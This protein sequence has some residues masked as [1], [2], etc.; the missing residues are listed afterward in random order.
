MTSRS[1]PNLVLLALFSVWG[2]WVTRNQLCVAFVS[3]SDPTSILRFA[4]TL[5]PLLL[6]VALLLFAGSL[7]GRKQTA[8]LGVALVLQVLAMT[9]TA[10][11]FIDPDEPVHLHYAWNLSQGLLPYRD[12]VSIYHHFWHL[13]MVP[14]MRMMAD[15]LRVVYLAKGITVLTTLAAIGVAGAV[16][17]RLGAHPLHVAL[18]ALSIGA[19]R[20]AATETRPDPFCLLLIL[21][22]VLCLQADSAVRAGLCVGTAYL[23]TQKSLLYGAALGAGYVMS[24]CKAR[25]FARFV[26]T[27]VAVSS[28]SFLIAA[29]LG[30][31]PDYWRG[32]YVYAAMFTRY[33]AKVPFWHSNAVF[34][35]LDEMQSSPLLWA[36]AAIGAAK[37]L[38]GSKELLV[39]T[40]FVVSIFNFLLGRI[41]YH[42][43]T[44]VL[45]L[46]LAILAAVGM[47][48]FTSTSVEKTLGA[49]S[50]SFSLLVLTFVSLSGWSVA[51]ST[52]L[53]QTEATVA[54]AAT[55]P[56]D[57]YHGEDAPGDYSSPI[58]RPQ[59]SY[60]DS[61]GQTMFSV[62]FHE[63]GYVPPE[64]EPLDMAWLPTSPPKVMKFANK[65]RERAALELLAGAGIFYRA[66][67][68]LWVRQDAS[69]GAGHLP[70]ISGW[71][72]LGRS[73]SSRP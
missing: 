22:A 9:D 21:L 49:A 71:S 33:F 39:P 28:L 67:K 57:T 70:S 43:Y 40:M 54:L 53:D 4:A 50:A 13:L 1:T 69:G 24:R 36:L 63:A 65:E 72:R 62:V 37:L 44:M 55:A 52:S 42:Q 18:C 46:L 23:V 31:L 47:A 29:L 48:R 30:L 2:A 26:A 20:A 32:C 19:V 41:Y 11:H 27:A 56:T 59:A 61:L 51:P 34:V 10:A 3:A 25:D 45:H 8:C 14:V 66:E 35:L 68:G 38:R 73:S 17:R 15:D 64:G 5:V 12:F 7:D 16:G 58:F 60:F 6:A